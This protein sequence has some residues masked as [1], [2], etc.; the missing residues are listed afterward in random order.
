MTMASLLPRSSQNY[1]QGVEDLSSQ[2]QEQDSHGGITEAGG[3]EADYEEMADHQSQVTGVKR[4]WSEDQDSQ[5]SGLSV[6]SNAQDDK[7]LTLAPIT[8]S[9][10]KKTKVSKPRGRKPKGDKVE[11]KPTKRVKKEVKTPPKVEP[12]GE[13]EDEYAEVSTNQEVPDIDNQQTTEGTVSLSE[14]TF[15]EPSQLYYSMNTSYDEGNSS[16]SSIDQ[17]F[18]QNSSSVDDQDDQIPSQSEEAG[19]ADDG[20]TENQDEVFEE[21]TEGKIED[22]KRYVCEFEGCNKSYTQKANRH[23][24][25]KKAH[26]LLGSR[27]AKKQRLSVTAAEEELNEVSSTGTSQN[28]LV[29]AEAPNAESQTNPLPTEY[30]SYSETFEATVAAVMEA[31]NSNDT[32]STTDNEEEEVGPISSFLTDTNLG[33]DAP[34]PDVFGTQEI[35]TDEREDLSKDEASHEINTEVSNAAEA[36]KE[37]E[38][39]VSSSKYFQKNPKMMQ[40]AREKSCLLFTEKSDILPAGWT[41][42]T[43]EVSTSSFKTIFSCVYILL[44]SGDKQ[45]DW[46][47]DDVQALLV[48]GKEGAQDWSRCHR[49]PQV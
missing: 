8:N 17:S 34:D 38:V 36:A 10:N 45:V 6:E 26:G 3:I 29:E 24:H 31:D 27:A 18:E 16:V 15:E 47:E 43:V 4:E 7:A 40:T 25:Q 49:V 1:G 39:D 23:T 14:E 46:G 28:D 12:E 30:A 41:F 35:S 2:F 42:R 5:V 19:T 20:T 21:K 32:A 11:R 22:A 44:I 37:A 33:F 9:K 48:A 13:H